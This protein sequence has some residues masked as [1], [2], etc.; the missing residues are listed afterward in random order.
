[1]IKRLFLRVAITLRQNW[2]ALAL[3]VVW[4]ALNALVFALALRLSPSEA[5]L[6]AL[7]L[8]KHESTWGRFYTSFTELAV[9]GAVASMIVANVTRR[10][11]PE[12]TCAALAAEA[13][14]HLVVIGYTNL[15][16]RARAIALDAGATAVVI[17]DDRSAVEALIRA[18]EP[19]VIG[20]ARDRATLLA[21][22]VDRAKVVVIACDDLETAALACRAVRAENPTC[23]LV[24]RCADD[25]VGQILAKTYAARALSTS[26]VAAGY[27]LARAQKTNPRRAVVMGKNN[28]GK[29]VS[30]A[31]SAA[32]IMTNLVD[33]TDDV[34]A[35]ADAGVAAA[36]LL[37]LADDDLGKNLVRADRIRDLSPDGLLL[38]R[39]FHDDAAELLTQK[40]F[41]CVVLS[42]SRISAEMLIDEGIFEGIGVTKPARK[43]R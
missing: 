11:R 25:D 26:R 18:E 21:A 3:T 19:L 6:T 32:G 38:C 7:C 28:V 41:R 10:Y 16:K 13:S 34:K 15:G 43:K 4:V 22:R 27:I 5:A 14:D 33:A 9:F 17:D 23:K 36:E 31:L 20:S 35:L 1:M 12:S 8:H 40:P 2:V 39:V 24:V 42:T 30:E 29:R 37:V